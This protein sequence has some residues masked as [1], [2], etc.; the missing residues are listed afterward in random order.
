MLEDDA[1]EFLEIDIE[2]ELPNM[3]PKL[4]LAVA[5]RRMLGHNSERKSGTSW[6]LSDCIEQL[7]LWR[8]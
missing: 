5:L 1:E 4:R 2:K 6:F 8:M 7:F 3:W